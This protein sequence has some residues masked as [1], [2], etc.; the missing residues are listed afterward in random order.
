M[1]NYLWSLVVSEFDDLRPKA[2]VAELADRLE[3]E[4]PTSP[5]VLNTL[6]VARFRLA[7]YGAALEALEEADR[8]NVARGGHMP[9][10]RLV[11]AICHQALGRQ[12][13]ARQ[14]LAET[15]P[16]LEIPGLPYD[17]LQELRSLQREAE[18]MILSE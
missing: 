11:I 14:I 8:L 1:N 9:H 18:G 12:D 3:A 7:E 10:D 4:E 6:G 16:L 2:L 17:D 13:R 15:A 5:T